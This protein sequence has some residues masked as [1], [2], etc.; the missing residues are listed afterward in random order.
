[1]K[2]IGSGAGSIAWI[3]RLGA[4]KVGPQSAG[5]VPGPACYGRGGEQAT[6]TD[7]LVVRGTLVPQHFL[8]GEMKIY[9]QE[10]ERALGPL[11]QHLGFNLAQ[12]G[13]AICDVLVANVSEAAKEISLY[14]G[15]DPGDYYMLAYGSAGPVFASE[16][17]REIGVKGVIIPPFPGEMCA[18]G[19][20]MSDLRLD[21]GESVVK[22]ISP[23][24][25]E[26]LAAVYQRLEAR[27][28][29]MFQRQDINPDQVVLS[30]YFDGR[31]MGQTWDTFSVPVP[32]GEIDTA[33]KEEMSQNFHRAHKRSWGYN[34]PTYSVKLIMARVS[35]T[36]SREK[37]RLPQIKSGGESPLEALLEEVQVYLDKEEH[38]AVPLYQREKLK[39]GNRVTGP[40]IVQQRTSTTV[41]LS[42]D[43]ALVDPYDN[44]RIT[45][46][47]S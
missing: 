11:A 31:Y 23:L 5:S 37:P 44:L 12:T 24:P 9:P 33:C 47:K 38:S 42:G 19:L 13:K 15:I 1:V 4:L 10:A 32:S 34:L 7:A 39:A 43:E 16:V 41:L 36:A 30:R 28:L 17:G 27:V 3:D 8:G 14:S 20:V 26:E 35:G 29:E 21:W 40:A 25:V 18:F 6:V 2:S 45:W 22:Q 46:G